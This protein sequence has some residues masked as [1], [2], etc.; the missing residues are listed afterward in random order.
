MNK[1]IDKNRDILPKIEKTVKKI[2]EEYDKDVK[3]GTPSNGYQVS[4]ITSKAKDAINE[5]K[6]TQEKISNGVKETIRRHA[7]IIQG[8]ITDDEV[9][10]ILMNPEKGQEMLQAKLFNAPSPQL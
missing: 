10:N 4:S 5:F 2:N 1:F 9:E 8:D 7:I 3:D 6:N